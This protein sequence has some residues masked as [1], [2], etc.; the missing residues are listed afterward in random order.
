MISRKVKT[1]KI[2]KALI[3]V[4]ILALFS[5]GVYFICKALGITNID[6]LRKIVED[7]GTWGVLTFIGIRVPFTM[8]MCFV[9]VIS[10]LFDLLA[11]ALFGATWKTLI[12]CLVSISICSGIMYILGRTG[13]YKIFEKIIGKKDLEKA[14]QLIK[15]KG[16]VFY[17][18]MMAVGGFPDDAL[19]LMAGIVKM[20]PIYFIIT[21]VLGRG[22]GCAFTIFGISLIPFDSFTRP[23]DWFVFVCCIIILAYIIIKGGNWLSNKINQILEKNYEEK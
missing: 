1:K 15:E 2:I 18:I 4:L 17:P 5:I 22:I 16:L 21:T 7:S 20:N 12:I 19:V 11:V 10:M 6:N 23:Y 9:P 14:N 13:A 8:F 3:I